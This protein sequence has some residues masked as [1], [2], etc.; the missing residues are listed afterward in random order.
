MGKTKVVR[1]KQMLRKGKLW[2]IKVIELCEE[3]QT[4]AWIVIDCHGKCK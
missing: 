1:K 2:K 3:M 4:N